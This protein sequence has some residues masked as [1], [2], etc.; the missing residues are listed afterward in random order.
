MLV[1]G[2]WILD[3]KKTLFL[4]F[5]VGNDEAVNWLL[6]IFVKCY[7]PNGRK[8]SIG[9]HQP[10]RE[11]NF[12]N[13]KKTG[14]R[15]PSPRRTPDRSPGQAPGSRKAFKEWIPAGVYPVLD[16]GPE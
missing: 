8:N 7:T 10:Q 5:A 1:T 16:T 3:R 11:I 2:F 12:I 9:N 13:L 15:L 4:E 6:S 14:L